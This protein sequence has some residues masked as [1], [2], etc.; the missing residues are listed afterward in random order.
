MLG[1]LVYCLLKKVKVIQTYT[2]LWSIGNSLCLSETNVLISSCYFF[3]YVSRKLC[4][5]NYCFANMRTCDVF[6]CRQ[7]KYVLWFETYSHVSHMSLHHSKSTVEDL[8][9]KRFHHYLIRSGNISA[10]HF[11]SIYSFVFVLPS[12][13]SKVRKDFK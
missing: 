12:G 11:P 9:V 8:H 7:L 2:S 6:K 10:S 1:F 5:E 3:F 13:I 4:G